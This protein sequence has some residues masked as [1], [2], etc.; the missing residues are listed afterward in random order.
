MAKE[1]K[2]WVPASIH[3]YTGK[4]QE[5]CTPGKPGCQGSMAHTGL[6]LSRALA[7]SGSACNPT[8]PIG[9]RRAFLGHYQN[10]VGTR[11]W[12]KPGGPREEESGKDF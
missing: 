11:L 4:R 2:I 9:P 3:T 10:G 12:E 8:I 5:R 6:W 7:S 1:K